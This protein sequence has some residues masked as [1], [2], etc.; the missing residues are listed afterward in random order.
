[1][2]PLGVSHG[3]IQ[4]KFI[5][6]TKNIFLFSIALLSLNMVNAQTDTGKQYRLNEVV[7]S[8]NK[9]LEKKKNVVQK[10]D[11][12][13][14]KDL[15][16]MN[17]QS[18]GDAL[19]NTGE[20]FV[21]KSQQGSGSPVIRGFEAS[22]I[23]LNIDGIRMNNAIYRSGHLQNSMTVD[24]NALERIEVLAGP[25]STVHGSDALGGVILMK[26]RDAKFTKG[27]KFEVT[28]AN[29]LVRY[30]TVNQEKTVNTGI[31][32]GNR[33]FASYT[34]ITY[35]KFEDLMSGKN[36]VD[37][38]MNLWKKNF[39]VE[40]IND[41]D[42]MV[43]NSNPFKMVSSGFSQFDVLQ[44]F[45][46][47]TGKFKH[48][49]N[50]QLSTS[51]DVP[52]Y[53]RLSETTNGVARSAEWYYGPQFRS[54]AAYTLEATHLEGFFQEINA[55]ISTQFIQESRNTRSFN[56]AGLTRRDENVLVPGYNFALRH[57]DEVHELTLG[58][59]A[60]FNFLKSTAT[61][62][63]IVTDLEKKVDTR[64]PDGNNN[65]NLFGLFYQHIMKFD[66]GRVVIN[67]GVRLNHSR[68]RS[69]LVDTAIQF[70]IPILELEQRNSAITGNL[71]IAYMPSDDLRLT[72]NF[73]TG[74]RS[75]NFDDLTK[76]FESNNSRLIVPN[77]KLKPEYTQNF[78]V[79]VQH[80]GDKLSINAFGFYTNY[81]NAFVVDRF[82]FEGNDSASYNGNTVAVFAMQNKAKAFLYG[83]GVNATY[84][85]T[86]E[87]SLFG[88]VNYTFGRFNQDTILVPLD[89]IPPV[90]GR[91][92]M[93][94]ETRIWYTELYS[95][96]NGNKKLSDY[97]ITGEDNLP[98]ATPNGTPSWYTINMRVGA[99]IAENVMLQ[100]G[101]ENILDRN[102]R[103]FASGIS[104]PGRNL[105]IAVRYNFDYQ[106]K[107]PS[108]FE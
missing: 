87:F 91:L 26:T 49:L 12:I 86:K 96:F 46:L 60:Q 54:L 43:E 53:D 68:L 23:Q 10:I 65:M 34:N 22:R 107:K 44:K 2:I 31:N 15:Q 100:L 47:K 27:K 62:T 93:K 79:G 108:I 36:G 69:T 73:S 56:K 3:N 8:G 64:Y 5:K 72:A 58:T 41:K 14:E 102:Y 11:I 6:M 103:Y 30:S 29:A 104:A 55:N 57:K 20:V 48:G 42:S 105:M 77:P 35:S 81:R 67:D 90:T 75:P 19:I 52:R 40:R 85:A 76:V 13:K 94:Y 4:F 97:N 106:V 32:W 95:L 70:K 16:Q 101:L 45:A 37:S 89:H 71:G 25:A 78:E 51:S 63:D 88:N 59:D 1:M 7:V 66:E 50:L 9:F 92:G 98:Y 28:G 38:I 82:N 33:Y 99:N 84:R 74:F 83:G 24:N 61:S 80:T 17:A 18:I 39:I 21:Q